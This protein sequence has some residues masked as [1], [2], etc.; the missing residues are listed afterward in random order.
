MAPNQDQHGDREERNGRR[1]AAPNPVGQSAQKAG[2]DRPQ[3]NS[4]PKPETE[5]RGG[6]RSADEQ[7]ADADDRN[8]VA[9]NRYGQAEVEEPVVGASPI[10]LQQYMRE[11]AGKRNAVDNRCH[12][13]EC[14]DGRGSLECAFEQEHSTDGPRENRKV[15]EGPRRWP[16]NQASGVRE[17]QGSGQQPFPERRNGAGNARG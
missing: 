12:S 6:G 14:D 17:E 8:R 13:E 9:A 10:S 7:V 15:T 4:R 1:T 11:S 2:R 3:H 5:Q 16:E